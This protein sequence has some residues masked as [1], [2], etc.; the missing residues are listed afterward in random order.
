MLTI[1]VL[2][3]ADRLEK[4]F[5]DHLSSGDYYV[6]GASAPGNWIGSALGRFGLA[7]HAAVTREDF[8]SLINNLHPRTGEMIT[9]RR[10]AKRRPAYDLVFSAP[11][12]VSIMSIALGDERLLAAHEAAVRF[13]FEHVEKAAQARVR[14]GL[15]KD[16]RGNRY[17][18]NLTSA[19]FTHHESRELDPQLHTHLVTMN[20]T[21]DPVEERFKALET[22]KIYA[23]ARLYTALYRNRLAEQCVNLGYEIERSR[24]GWK[25][26]GVSEDLEK[27]FSKRSSDMKKMKEEL[28]KRGVNVGNNGMSTIAQ[29][30]RKKK[31]KGLSAAE[32]K[33]S[34]LRQMSAAEIVNLQALIKKG[35]KDEPA[36]P[37]KPEVQEA[38]AHIFER[39]SVVSRAELLT[40][41]LERCAGSADLDDIEAELNSKEYVVRG[42]LITTKAERLREGAILAAVAAAPEIAPMAVP[43]VSLNPSLNA[44]QSAAANG[45]LNSKTQY[46]ILRGRA[47]TGKTFTLKEI[48]KNVSLPVVA[49][50][51]TTSATETLK[52]D[53]FDAQTLASLLLEHEKRQGPG[54]ALIILDEAG[55]VSNGDMLKL[56]KVAADTGS[57]IL[58]V[59]D[60][61]QH[62]SIA[63]GDSLRLLETFSQVPSFS[64]NQIQRQKDPTYKLAV[65]AISEGKT[66]A[67]F[68][69]LDRAGMIHELEVEESWTEEQKEEARANADL[70]RAAAVAK[71]YAEHTKKGISTLVVTPTWAE[72]ARVSAAIREELK[73]E[74]QL[75][76]EEVKIQ[77]E[78]PL[79][80]SDSEK[81]SSDYYSKGDEIH[82]HAKSGDFKAG[83]AATVVEKR[84]DGKLVVETKEKKKVVID[85]GR[86]SEKYDVFQKEE[87]SFAK[88]DQILVK[89]NLI[90]HGKKI[91]TNGSRH[92]IKDISPEGVIKL[93]SG[94]EIPK[95]FRTF[96]HGY[97]VT[98]IAAQGMTD[99][100]NILSTSSRDAA[101]LSIQQTYVS[102]SRGRES[103]AIYTDD[104]EALAIAVRRDR[105]RA[106]AID[107]AT[108]AV[109]VDAIKTAKEKAGAVPADFEARVDRAVKEARVKQPGADEMYKKWQEKEMQLAWRRQKE[110]IEKTKGAGREFGK[111]RG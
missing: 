17:T 38:V 87:R 91:L 6:E 96:T 62:N 58:L 64:L 47:G 94:V 45:V 4:Y 93:E 83:E 76:K 82:F 100:R 105:S 73:A 14:L 71:D 35:K 104:K 98:S 20:L 24:H 26:K 40:Y 39:K 65:R 34:I 22:G 19:A 48:V 110:N 56:Q 74:G 92:K 2:K 30:T 63:A 41:V 55:F 16:A 52:R 25:I 31:E 37:K 61:A 67:A 21:F 51:S 5:D 9:V 88:G 53:G 69:I 99:T 66:D 8:L 72:H 43:Q 90:D 60:T 36:L 59:G 68:R 111:G 49:L 85:P 54:K 106:F 78:R 11:K 75:D 57:K 13:A 12:S 102:L 81:R 95:D 18:G 84:G 29:K 23:N 70:K 42:D 80:L 27:R 89:G 33:D 108:A 1:R 32:F 107:E 77:I 7:P 44:E 10:N 15:E 97:A 109:Y 86:A 79:G 101:A 46:M 28:E 103:V 3:S 50:G